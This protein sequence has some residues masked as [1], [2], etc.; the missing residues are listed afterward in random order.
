MRAKFWEHERKYIILKEVGKRRFI[1]RRFTQKEKPFQEFIKRTGHI[2]KWIKIILE[3]SW[4]ILQLAQ[5]LLHSILSVKQRYLL[6][7]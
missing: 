3:I 7:K 1:H 2:L 4:F 6:L 5:Y